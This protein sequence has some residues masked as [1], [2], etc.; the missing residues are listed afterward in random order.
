M[1]IFGSLLLLSLSSSGNNKII[2][3]H[4]IFSNIFNFSF[5][6]KK[7]KTIPVADRGGP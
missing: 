6:N 1:Q 3:M 4:F 5:N 2:S 7:N